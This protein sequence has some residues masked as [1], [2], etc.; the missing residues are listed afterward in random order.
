[1]G[2]HSPTF[3]LRGMGVVSVG[4]EM[5]EEMVFCIMAWHIYSHALWLFDW[6]RWVQGAVYESGS[7]SGGE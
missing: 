5:V 7:G 3:S 4:C 2:S 6:V 1:M